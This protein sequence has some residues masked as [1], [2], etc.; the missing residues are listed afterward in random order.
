[1][2]LKSTMKKFAASE[3]NVANNLIN[4]G[5]IN[6]AQ[7]EI[8]NSKWI[9]PGGSSD[10]ENQTPHKY[11]E[12]KDFKTNDDNIMT[13]RYGDL[14]LVEKHINTQSN[15]A[16]TFY[17]GIIDG[18]YKLMYAEPVQDYVG[19]F[20]KRGL[21]EKTKQGIQESN[22]VAPGG[23]QKK[24][25]KY[26]IVDQFENEED[27]PKNTEEIEK[28]LKEQSGMNGIFYFGIYQG[29]DCL[30]YTEPVSEN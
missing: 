22:W 16:G 27:V 12:I 23:S 20:Y 1:M 5:I 2:R 25:H 21:L 14:D 15:L 3:E 28:T 24:P 26:F 30:F 29:I 18:S 8:K 10:F 11:C 19:D 6:K 4:Q 7:E 13:E 17:F 9:A